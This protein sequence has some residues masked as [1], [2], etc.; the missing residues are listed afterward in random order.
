MGIGSLLPE[1]HT[2]QLC[3]STRQP[4]QE[5]G[6]V[7]AVLVALFVP[8]KTCLMSQRW[9][10]YTLILYTLTM[11]TILVITTGG[12]FKPKRVYFGPNDRCRQELIYKG[13]IEFWNERL[14]LTD[15]FKPRTSSCTGKSHHHRLECTDT[16]C[17]ACPHDTRLLVEWLQYAEEEIISIHRILS[18]RATDVAPLQLH[19]YRLEELLKEVYGWMRHEEDGKKWTYVDSHNNVVDL[20]NVMEKVL[21]DRRWQKLFEHLDS[22]TGEGV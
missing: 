8:Y 14:V 11:D 7:S 21:G 22:Y 12:S 19:L 2:A 9:A 10:Q 1:R 17:R 3:G 6:A 4:R 20:K 16:T 15:C 18:T 13:K 5:G